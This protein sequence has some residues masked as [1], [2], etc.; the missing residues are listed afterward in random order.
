MF[1]YSKFDDTSENSSVTLKTNPD[2]PIADQI[3]PSH[4]DRLKA[5]LSSKPI[6]VCKICFKA[7]FFNAVTFLSLVF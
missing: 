6:H 1:E 7:S 4:R 5:I 3:A 2:V